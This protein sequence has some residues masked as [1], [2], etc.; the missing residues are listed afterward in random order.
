MIYI[1]YFGRAGDPNG[2]NFWVNELTA[3]G[4]VLWSLVSMTVI[5][6][7]RPPAPPVE[8]TSRVMLSTTRTSSSDGRNRLLAVL[9][10]A[11]FSL[12]APNLKNISLSQGEVLQEAGEPIN[13]DIPS[14][15]FGLL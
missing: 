3:G 1:A 14:R 6:P 2:T 11:D 10:P 9:A 8:R 7:S 12:L 5:P 13:N 15:H 4:D